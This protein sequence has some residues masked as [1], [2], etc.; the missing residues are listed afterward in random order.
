MNP[1]RLMFYLVL[2]FGIFGFYQSAAVAGPYTDDLSKCIVESTTEA[3]RLEFVKW[4][5]SAIAQHPA[6]KSFSQITEQQQIEFDR[7]A[8]ELFMKL[9]TETCRD[10]AK[11][12]IQFEGQIAIQ[13]SFNVLGQVAAQELMRDPDVVA[14]VS[15]MAKFMDEKKLQSSLGVE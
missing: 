4:M 14:A 13:Q 5:F 9:L 11:N 8:A 6:A 7:N 3:E 15:N 12:A 10:K 1:S 2:V